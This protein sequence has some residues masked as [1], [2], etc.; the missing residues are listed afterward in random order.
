[1]KL[2]SGIC[3]IF[4]L[5]LLASC[6][7]NIGPQEEKGLLNWKRTVQEQTTSLARQSIVLSERAKVGS[8]DELRRQ[9]QTVA[10]L[11]H[12]LEGMIGGVP[13][14]RAPML[15]L[16]MG[17]N[18]EGDDKGSLDAAV[19]KAYLP[20]GMPLK[21][22][23]NLLHAVVEPMLWRS[24]D[25]AENP[26]SAALIGA[27]QALAEQ[28]IQLRSKAQAWQ[29]SREDAFRAV[30]ASFSYTGYR[31][32]QWSEAKK[33]ASSSERN[34]TFPAQS[35]LVGLRLS[36]EGARTLYRMTLYHALE[37]AER[38]VLEQDFKDVFDLLQT[39]EADDRKGNSLSE[40]Q[41]NVL[42][43]KG[44]A[45]G[46]RASLHLVEYAQR[47]GLALGADNS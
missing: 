3:F 32:Y 9:W 46:E 35:R 5:T 22:S 47:L 28:T 17:L 20:N 7:P 15:A 16:G 21:V 36:L 31:I 8:V 37:P 39:I 24:G 14:F 12:P 40:A 29:P 42:I 4:C 1:M 43:D 30:E 25:W 34:E 23:G 11:Y 38:K 6:G 13:H 2:W 45:L 33:G 44:A 26:D 10:D 27:T 41:R 18:G 19:Y